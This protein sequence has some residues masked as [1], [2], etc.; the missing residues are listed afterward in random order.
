MNPIR[1]MWR[2][3]VDAV[4]DELPWMSKV[5]HE[6]HLDHWEGVW[7]RRME[8]EL[9]RQDQQHEAELRSLGQKRV[10]I[11]FYTT[12]NSPSVTIAELSGNGFNSQLKE[13]RV[14]MRHAA[15]VQMLDEFQIHSIK[16]LQHREGIANAMADVAAQSLVKRIR[17]ELREK[18]LQ[19]IM[20]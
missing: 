9:Q 5:Q 14:D 20:V 4:K 19:A 18:I 6:K 3:F 11:S 1:R 7:H 12:Q 16:H 13:V 8:R 15:H 10:N 17:E 2:R